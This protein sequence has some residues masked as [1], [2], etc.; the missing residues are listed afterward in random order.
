MKDRN[1][2]Q[3]LSPLS[4]LLP[5]LTSLQSVILTE[6]LAGIDVTLFITYDLGEIAGQYCGGRQVIYHGNFKMTG[7]PHFCPLKGNCVT[8]V[9]TFS[10]SIQ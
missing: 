1:R 10:Q 6:F 3:T 8:L 9:Q 2:T 4:G 7:F 5:L